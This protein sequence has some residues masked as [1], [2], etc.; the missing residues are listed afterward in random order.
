MCKLGKGVIFV[1]LERGMS[2]LVWLENTKFSPS[3]DKLA[4]GGLMLLCPIVHPPTS[5][6]LMST[7][8]IYSI[9]VIGGKYPLPP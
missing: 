6:D 3:T 1:T 9:R 5:L 8:I 2:V 4:Y 7:E